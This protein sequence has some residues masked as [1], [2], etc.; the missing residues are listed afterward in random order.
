MAN[1]QDWGKQNYFL[2]QEA[3][4]IYSYGSPT[5]L[6]TAAYRTAWKIATNAKH[7]CYDEHPGSPP[8]TVADND[9]AFVQ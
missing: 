4:T 3:K 5:R 2:A 9:L 7:I 1:N 8:L 6:P